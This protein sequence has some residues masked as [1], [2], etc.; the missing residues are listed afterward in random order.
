MD[1]LQELSNALDPLIQKAE[2][3]RTNE[4]AGVEESVSAI[5]SKARASL[6][7]LDYHLP[8]LP[9]KRAAAKAYVEERLK[10]L[11]NAP[12]PKPDLST[13]ELVVQNE[14][15]KGL[16]LHS[17]GAHIAYSDAVKLLPGKNPFKHPRG[18]KF[19]M[20]EKDVRN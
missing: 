3:A 20:E 13:E 14:L 18:V 19:K 16:N 7:R 5:A 2:E 4:Q 6:R 12:R 9:G 10:A 8:P 1:A 11:G 15:L 17:N